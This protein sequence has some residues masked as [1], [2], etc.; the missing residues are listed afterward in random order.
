[1]GTARG[2]AIRIQPGRTGDRTRVRADGAGTGAWDFVWSPLA[3]GLLTGKYTKDNLQAGRLKAVANSGNPAFDRITANPRNW[4][5]VDALNQIAKDAGRPVAQ[6][7]LNWIAKR[8][9]VS[10]TLIGASKLEQL[11]TNLQ[12]L[13]FDLPAELSAK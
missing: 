3:S 13:D 2:P 12:A 6:V 10:S 11:R 7:A 4:Q 8:P 9:G 1:M 5:I